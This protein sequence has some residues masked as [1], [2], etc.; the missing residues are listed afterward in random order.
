MIRSESVSII[1]YGIA[2]AVISAATV[3][4]FLAA[5]NRNVNI[6]DK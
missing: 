6:D 4:L 2:F 1:I 5:Y 3:P